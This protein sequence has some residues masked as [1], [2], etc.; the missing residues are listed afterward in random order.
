MASLSQTN[1]RLS[2]S[3]KG[4]DKM[5]ISFSEYGLPAMVV[6]TM[7]SISIAATRELKEY[8]DNLRYQIIATNIAKSDIE[9]T[10]NLI[11]QIAND[12]STPEDIKYILKNITEVIVD[13]NLGRQVA[14]RFMSNIGDLSYREKS[15]NYALDSLKD[16]EKTNSR[17]ANEFKA[18]LKSGIC[19]LLLM[20]SKKPSGEIAI[21]KA[22]MNS[23]GL[24]PEIT[25]VFDQ[26]DL[27]GA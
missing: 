18:V 7:I 19:A 4:E 9:K 16:L 5:D 15:Y 10:F 27:V 13:K 11:E 12:S 6:I 17:I 2:M 25:K 1:K 3:V 14:Q 26:V 24:I 20:H 22:I 8:R 23:S 21:R